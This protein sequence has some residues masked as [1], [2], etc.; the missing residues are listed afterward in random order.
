MGRSRKK[1][2]NITLVLSIVFS[3]ICII[4]VLS[5]RVGDQ[6]KSLQP[7]YIKPEVKDEI[8]D[9]IKPKASEKD[10]IKE[11]FKED[12]T[13]KDNNLQKVTEDRSENYQEISVEDKKTTAIDSKLENKI[14]SFFEELNCS[15]EEGWII[16]IPSVYSLNW[17]KRRLDNTLSE[18]GYSIKDTT[19]YLNGKEVLKLEFKK[20]PSKGKVAIIIDDVGR[21]TRLNGILQEIKLPL[22]ISILPKQRE[23]SNMSLIGKKEGWDVLLHLPM[24]PKEKSWVDSTFITTNMGKEEIKEKVDNYLKSLPY[25]QGINN[26]M[27]SL[28]TA[29]EN[30]MT[31]VLSI[32][33]ER[34]LYFVDSLTISNS[35]GEK[36][37]R[38]INL[39]RFAK[40]DVFIDNLDEREYIRAQIDHLVEI[41]IRKG[42]AIGIGHLRENTLLTIRDYEWNNKGI[43]LILLSD[44]L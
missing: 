18:I 9:D 41:S 23:G 33:K 43:E 1:S 15:I 22:N 31:S 16:N 32:I 26:H 25:V 27:G 2:L 6:K 30:I 44:I 17:I 19:I 36:V 34:G 13:T 10:L 37:A 12:K 7:T 42:F 5:V 21:A 35:V 39:N 24:E 29:D 40:R 11:D 4:A 28:A 14:R 38:D 3:V 20:M 8:Y